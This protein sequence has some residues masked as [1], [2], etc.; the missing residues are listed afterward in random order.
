MTKLLTKKEVSELFGVSERTVDR[1][2]SA[3][4]VEAIRVGNVV[5]FRPESIDNALAK[6][7]KQSRKAG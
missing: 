3:G 7:A 5:R 6:M 1:W 4:I 2:R